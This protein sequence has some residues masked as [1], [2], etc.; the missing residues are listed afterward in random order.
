MEKPLVQSIPEDLLR[1]IVKFTNS[2]SIDD[3]EALLYK[4]KETE[5]LN[6]DQETYINERIAQILKQSL[7]GCPVFPESKSEECLSASI[8]SPI[9]C[10]FKMLCQSEEKFKTCV[11]NLIIHVHNQIPNSGFLLLHYLKVHGKLQARRKEN[12][13]SAFKGNIYQS[14][15]EIVNSP[16]EN[17][18]KIDLAL[19]ERSNSRMFFWI[20]PDLFKEYKNVMLNNIDVLSLFI[21]AIDAN[22]LRDI[23]FN[24][25]Q[26][27]LV[28][29]SNDDIIDVIRESL[30]YET[31]EQFCFWQL[32]QAHDIPLE[33]FQ[34]SSNFT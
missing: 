6:N 27:K 1:I 11:S 31:F 22:N 20:L 16:F 2:K 34:V 25:T 19:L 33:S 3:F 9:F 4:L 13:T 17:Q 12:V 28:M 10:L 24:V 5:S 23:I 14:F 8:S 18:L 32:I 26:G 7:V 29:F 15:C 21:G 30:E